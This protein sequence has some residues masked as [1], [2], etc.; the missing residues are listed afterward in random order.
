MY[1]LYINIASG[2]ICYNIWKG[3]IYRI[4][5]FLKDIFSFYMYVGIVLYIE[6]IS[7]KVSMQS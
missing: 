4:L 6:A 1:D 3:F 5:I 2:E 7:Q